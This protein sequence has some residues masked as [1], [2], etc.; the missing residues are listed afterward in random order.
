ML[1]SENIEQKLCYRVKRQ[2][3]R[4]VVELR[5]RAKFMLQMNTQN[6]IELQSKQI[7]RNECYRVKIWNENFLQIA[8]IERKKCQ[9]VNRYNEF[10]VVE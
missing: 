2:N 7:G 3:D 9:G 6:K 4:I 8:H 10:Y 1:Q 5:D